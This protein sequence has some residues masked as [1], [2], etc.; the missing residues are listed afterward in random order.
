MNEREAL[1]RCRSD[2]PGHLNGKGSVPVL[3][4]AS[5]GRE[6]PAPSCR[7]SSCRLGGWHRHLSR[8][9]P[10]CRRLLARHSLAVPF[11]RKVVE[12]S[13]GR[14]PAASRCSHLHSARNRIDA[15]RAFTV[16]K[17]CAAV[18][19]MR[20]NIDVPTFNCTLSTGLRL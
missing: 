12:V 20:P 1:L 10:V 8:H 2:R 11:R 18:C 5:R 7:R 13:R 19:A 6:N 4:V 14:T 17:P 16:E 3:V 9:V 15:R